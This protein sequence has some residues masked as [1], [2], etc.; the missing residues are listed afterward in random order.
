ME[1][2]SVEA[3]LSAVDKGFTDSM[4]SADKS[5]TNLDSNT[6]KANASILDI[7]KGVGVFKLVDAGIGMVK[8]SM[9]G[10]I[11]RFDTLN[12]YQDGTNH[13][14]FQKNLIPLPILKA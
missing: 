2:Y 5:M 13:P 10:A 6:Q 9:D 8:N 12:K 11:N 7:A 14:L 3:I 4:R 1:S